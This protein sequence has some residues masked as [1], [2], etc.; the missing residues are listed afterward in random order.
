MIKF[1]IEQCA[2]MLSR[3]TGA[4]QKARAKYLRRIERLLEELDPTRQYPFDYI[5]YRVIGYCIDQ[6]TGA[7]C[8]GEDFKADLTGLAAEIRPLT[9][10]AKLEKAK[11]GQ[12]PKRTEPADLEPEPAYIFEP[13]FEDE[14]FDKLIL[15]LGGNS[16]KACGGRLLQPDEEKHLFRCYNYCKFKVTYQTRKIADSLDRFSV[17]EEIN[18]YKSVAL[19]CRNAI[20][21]ANIGLVNRATIQHI[22]RNLAFEELLSDGNNSLMRAVENFDYRKGNRFSTYATWVITKNFARSIPLENLLRKSMGTDS[23]AVL[24]TQPE[25]EKKY[26]TRL[27][28]RLWKT[29]E[30]AVEKLPEKERIAVTYFFGVHGAP[31][32][33]REIAPKLGIKSKEL[34][35]T[36]K[37]RGLRRLEEILDSELYEEIYT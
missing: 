26:K 30:E 9:L 12:Q 17:I 37:D 34:V 25:N 6:D 24:K 27:L 29:I 35:R 28:P 4:P 22:G 13:A 16:A 3:L 36:Y 5:R 2:N 11:K 10:V 7:L 8:L 15:R 23:E 1:R 31:I 18:F 19:Q 33:L 32:S 20:I 14:G 21:E